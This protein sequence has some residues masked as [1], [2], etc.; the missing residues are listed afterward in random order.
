MRDINRCRKY[1]CQTDDGWV[2][3]EWTQLDVGDVV[4]QYP[5]MEGDPFHTDVPFV[6]EQLPCLNVCSETEWIAKQIARKNANT[7]DKHVPVAE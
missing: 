3:V 5:A 7:G 2:P 6:I 1:E 4:R